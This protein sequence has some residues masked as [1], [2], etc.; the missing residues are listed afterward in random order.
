MHVQN[1]KNNLLWDFSLEQEFSKTPRK[2]GYTFVIDQFAAT[3]RLALYRV[4][5][6]SS[7]TEHLEQQPPKELLVK[8]LG[9]QCIDPSVDGLFMI[10]QELRDWIENN[11]LNH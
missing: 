4:G 11:I 9:E 3:P 2:T 6:F 1:I 5:P 7:H 8:V 10:N